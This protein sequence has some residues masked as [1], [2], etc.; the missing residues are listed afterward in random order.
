MSNAMYTTMT[1][2]VGELTLVQRDGALVLIAFATDP[3]QPAAGDVRDDAALAPAAAELADYFAGTRTEFTVAFRLKGTD[4]QVEV[5]RALAAIPPGTTA[6][7]GEL[8]AAIGRPRAVRAVGAA[9]GRNPLPV[10]IPCHR[11][12]GADGRL[13]GYRGGLDAKGWLLGHEGRLALERAG[14]R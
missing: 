6:S 13:T 14:R 10:I 9:C 8:A 3:W 2:P 5:W 1:S 12:V 4:F 11:A 7:Y